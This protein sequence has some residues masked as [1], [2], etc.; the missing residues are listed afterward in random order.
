MALASVHVPPTDETVS[1]TLGGLE[2][3]ELYRLLVEHR[4]RGEPCDAG[5]APLCSLCRIR[6]ALASAYHAVRRDLEELERI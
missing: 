4:R 6:L 5:G 2:A 1:L 3:R